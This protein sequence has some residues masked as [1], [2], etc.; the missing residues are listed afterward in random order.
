MTRNEVAWVASDRRPPGILGGHAER[1]GEC[2]NVQVIASFGA[3]VNVA[4]CLDFQLGQMI[5]AGYRYVGE[6]LALIKPMDI[7]EVPGNVADLA[8]TMALVVLGRTPWLPILP[9]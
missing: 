3:R 1:Q 9:I 6:P 2:P 8:T 4:Y 7:S 5:W